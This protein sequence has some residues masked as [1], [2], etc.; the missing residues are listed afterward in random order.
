MERHFYPFCT[1]ETHLDFAFVCKTFKMTVEKLTIKPNQPGILMAD[2]ANAITNGFAS[3][4]GPHFVQLMCFVHVERSCLRRFNGVDIDEKNNII[5][6]LQTIQIS[7]TETVF[8]ILIELF[9][10]NSQ[11]NMLSL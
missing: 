2:T 4:F 1:N 3:V 7:F 11:Q 6:D 8:N 9:K 10:I 5:R